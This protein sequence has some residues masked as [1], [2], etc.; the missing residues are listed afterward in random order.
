MYFENTIRLP[1]KY[2]CIKFR[3][4]Q[5]QFSRITHSK[6]GTSIGGIIKRE[7]FAKKR[8]DTNG[9]GIGFPARKTRSENASRRAGNA[10]FPGCLFSSSRRLVGGPG[11]LK[12][13][14][15]HC[16]VWRFVG[17]AFAFSK[18]VVWCVFCLVTW[19]DVW[20]V[21]NFIMGKEWSHVM[22][23]IVPSMW[24]LL[25]LIIIF[26]NLFN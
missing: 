13:A 24:N 12:I 22:G 9:G 18:T 20:C 21:L 4:A 23:I 7:N 26:F 5:N 10:S 8:C 19:R 17:C 14:V 11:A 25:E 2:E 3:F 16:S 15:L 1:F 6:G